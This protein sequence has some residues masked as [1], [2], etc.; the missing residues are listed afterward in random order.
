MTVIIIA[1]VAVVL[2]LVIGL[3]IF[4]L[5]KSAQT[6]V[7]AVTDAQAARRP[8]VVGVD[9]RGRPVTDADEPA[10]GPRD[11]SSFEDLLQDEIRDRGMEQPP[12]D[13]EA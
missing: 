5:M 13:D 2:V 10:A 8:Q 6:D 1:A 9:E 3:L 4:R 11:Q 12:A 7:P